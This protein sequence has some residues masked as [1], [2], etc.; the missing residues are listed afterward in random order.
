MLATPTR[1]AAA[2][3]WWFAKLAGGLSAA[4]HTGSTESPAPTRV[5]GGLTGPRP[6][7]AGDRVAQ[8]PR[9]PN[10]RPVGEYL[11]TEG[12]LSERD[13]Q[14][15]LLTQT[16]SGGLVGEI[17]LA[18]GAVDEWALA[19]ALARQVGV[20]P[21]RADDEATSMLP[22]ARART[23]RAV[24][25][26]GDEAADGSPVPLA[27]D[28]MDEGVL[29]EVEAHL[30][31][32]VR[33][34]LAHE[35]RLDE[36]LATAYAA[37]DVDLVIGSLHGEAP[38][39]SAYGTRL[40]RTQRAALALVVLFCAVGIIVFPGALATFWVA[41]CTAIFLA[42]VG[43]RVFVASRGWEAGATID[44]TA[45]DLAGLD[46][47]RLPTYTI[48]LPLYKEKKET[49]QQLFEALSQLEYPK[50][51]IDGLLLVEDDDG[52]TLEA[53]Q[54][55]SPAPW[56]RIVRVPAG[57]PR[58]KP[59]AMVYGLLR[60]RGTYLTVYD[61]E[62]KPDPLQ[63][64]KAAWAFEHVDP[65][66]VCLQAKLG[67]YNARQ[68]L[69]TRWFGLE[70]DD[71]FNL[72]LPGLHRMQAP[73]PLGG[74]SNHFR[75]AFLREVIAWDPYNVTE[76]AD[77]GLR[78]A[79][80]GKTT[81]M[82]ESTTSEEANSRLPNWFRQRSR[83]IKGYL[84]TVIVHT[85]H[86]RALYR[87]LG[88]RKCLFFLAAFG[89]AVVVPLVA[90]VFWTLLVLWLVAQPGWIAELFSG[91]I[92]Y[93]ALASFVLGGFTLI[94]FG[95]LAAVERGHDDQAPYALL[96]PLYWILISAG[97]YLAVVELVLRPYHWHKTEHGLHLAS[98]ET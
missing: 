87:D 12:A 91:W 96:V 3:L 85:R 83:W 66:T 17:L 68:N 22:A 42:L 69:L 86:P 50:Q 10:H 67:Y 16:K 28:E 25:L 65:S 56:L 84:Q 72:F 47:R 19:S 93:A 21:V 90:P 62:D 51:K 27:V 8:A 77:L 75:T 78:L 37:D 82:L 36:L 20:E 38:E 4:L 14:A 63:L 30:E 73:I 57:L 97:A 18:Q 5:A 32:P 7:A 46:E 53:I 55:L 33:A 79:R 52:E 81:A 60:A 44:P 76:D 26:A 45:A 6:R 88:A 13:L 64:K 24:A 59:K 49:L 23:W 80:L 39:L 35:N 1:G 98:E 70:Y 2:K 95:L 9:D 29:G 34:K 41:V 58:T 43:F 89:G 31:R 61:A 71:W 74:T 40:S 15:A 11:R 94:F 92:Y 54:A 48:L